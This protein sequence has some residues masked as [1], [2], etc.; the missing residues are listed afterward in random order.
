M[1]Q[2]R[3]Q[4][5]LTPAK[6][7]RKPGSGKK[8]IIRAATGKVVYVSVDLSQYANG[9]VF[10]QVIGGGGGHGNLISLVLK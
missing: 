3:A 8:H 10:L 5:V 6:R 2:W 4:K 7:G 9:A 1:A